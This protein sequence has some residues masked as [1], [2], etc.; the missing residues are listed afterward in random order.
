MN[1]VFSVVEEAARRTPVRYDCDVIVLGAGSAGAAAA[2]AAARQGARVLL[3]ERHGFVGGIMSACSLGTICGLY[4][5]DANDEPYSLVGGIPAEV[6]ERLHALG[7]A[8]APKRWVGAVTVPYDLFL[9][10]VAFDELL[11][12][13]GVRVALHAQ[14]VAVSSAHGR[15]EAV[16][17]E[18][19]SGRWAARAPMIIDATGDADVVHAAGGAFEYDLSTLQ[20]PTTTFRLG[21]VSEAVARSVGRDQL[22]EMLEVANERGAGLPRTCGGVYF[23]TP[24]T[25]HLNLTRITRNG[26]P[27]NPLDTFELSDAEFEG[28]RQVLAYHKAFREFVPGYTDAF[29]VDSGIHI[30][31][32]E[33]RRVIGD[34]QLTLSD[35]Q[36]GRRFE[37]PIA[38]CSWPVEVHESGTQTR[39]DWLPPGVFYQLPWRCLLPRGL[40][41]VIVAGRCLSATHDAHGSVRVTATCMAMGQAAGT[42]AALAAAGQ[43]SD[44]RALDYQIL[45]ESLVAQGCLLDA[46]PARTAATSCCE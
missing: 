38:L 22:K 21:G 36:D 27:P 42:A 24:G 3:I 46:D 41:N 2:L 15:V 25:P 14:F 10:K 17:I 1:Q 16:F 30:G 37:D 6:V 31:V 28:R 39:W 26:N 29:V 8:A 40:A 4:G 44:I 11:R 35:V 20:L 45:R 33:S 19:K 9:L 13:A 23:Q 5:I 18:D 7:G 43:L 12:E 32:R 34:Y